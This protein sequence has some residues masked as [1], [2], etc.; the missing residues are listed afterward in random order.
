MLMNNTK[1][2]VINQMWHQRIQNDESNNL[3][4]EKYFPKI[5]FIPYFV[6]FLENWVKIVNFDIKKK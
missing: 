3:L 5:I 6:H 2:V 1:I 4:I